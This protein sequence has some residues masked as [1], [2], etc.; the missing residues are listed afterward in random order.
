M[1]QR[2][3]I[4]I[5]DDEKGIQTSLLGVLQDEGYRAE[6]VGSGEEC[7]ECLKEHAYDAIVLDVWLPK[8]SGLDVL[9]HLHQDSF[10]GA[11]LMISGHG[12]IEMAVKATR[13]GACD[14][15]EKPLSIEKTLLAIHNALRHSRLEREHRSLRRRYAAEPR[16]IGESE[17]MQRLRRDLERAAASSASVL[18]TGES[19]TGKE[20]AARLLHVQSDRK[21]GSFVELNCAALPDEL[22]ESEL[23]GYVKGAFTGA[24]THKPGKLEAADGGTLFLDEVG[25][26]SLKTQA[27]ALRAIEE[28]RFMRVGGTR[29]IEVD[30]RVLAA[31]NKNLLEEIRAG[32]FREDLYFRLNV[33]PISLPPL[34]ERPQDIP[35]LAHHFMET[36]AR[37]Y[38]RP[39]KT[40]PEEALA[41]MKRYRWPGNVRELRNTIERLLI[42]APGDAVEASDLPTAVQGS[43]ADGADTFYDS[44]L[45]LREARA[46]FEKALISARLEKCGGNVSLTASRLGVERSHL[47]RKLRAYGISPNERPE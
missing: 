45:S 27:K 15:I 39:P 8:M 18:L 32:R 43:P 7:L 26:M 36:L 17:K 35:L 4:L 5:V 23:F 2:E 24:A 38:G 37:E 20:L 29:S 25:D 6:A 11:V 9:E 22:I 19:G 40:F 28:R 13:M 42:M 1:P 14:F 10:E 41:H 21:D 31:T 33:I 3:R 44:N 34:R 47:Y 46:A 12:S 16:L 30:V